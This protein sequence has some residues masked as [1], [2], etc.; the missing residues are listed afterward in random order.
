MLKL[1]EVWHDD[2]A[3]KQHRQFQEFLSGT[4][5][6]SVDPWTPTFRSPYWRDAGN[7]VTRS[8]QVRPSFLRDICSP[9]TNSGMYR[10]CV[11]RMRS[12]VLTACAFDA[13]HTLLRVAGVLLA[14]S[15]VCA[16]LSLAPAQW[17]GLSEPT[18]ESLENFD[19]ET[20]RWGKV[21]R[22]SLTHSSPRM[23]FPR[24][25]VLARG[26]DVGQCH[27]NECVPAAGIVSQLVEL[28][29]ARERL[30]MRKHVST[31]RL[32]M[33]VD[34]CSHMCIDLNREHRIDLSTHR[35]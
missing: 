33:L 9:S 1:F 28:E 21:P 13:G 34:I 11:S 5:I 22:H 27:D 20:W 19:D 29:G 25:V 32:R 12:R 18:T 30:E 15:L 14:L 10:Y 6:G 16:V 24:R 23:S 17:L 3:P 26:T 31:R 4:V 7:A 8:P 35:P 2:D